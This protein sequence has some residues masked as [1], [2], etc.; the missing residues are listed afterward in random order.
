MKARSC[1]LSVIDTVCQYGESELVLGRWRDELANFDV[2]TKTPNFS[3][4][5]ITPSD[6]QQLR[7]TFQRSLR[8]MGLDSIGGLLIHDG[9]NLLLPG[10]ER[11][12]EELLRLKKEGYVR[13]IGISGYS[14][15]VVE[16]IVGTFSL[17]LVQL[18]VNLL[19]RRLTEGGTLSRLAASGVEIHA[20]SAFLQG[21]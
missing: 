13:R 5:Q 18:P 16:K 1:G 12:Y 19:D 15:D 6:A 3:S 9:A 8:L 11:L 2:I 7:L 4:E 20:R 17:D 21:L 10:G 14:G